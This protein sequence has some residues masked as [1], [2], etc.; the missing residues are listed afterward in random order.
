MLAPYL[1]VGSAIILGVLVFDLRSVLE[2][3]YSI[4]SRVV[5]ANEQIQT[6]AQAGTQGIRDVKF[7][8]SQGNFE[9]ISTTHSDSSLSLPLQQDAISQR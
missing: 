6:T 1:T 7:S 8:T 2:S 9:R 4:G 3:E 5:D